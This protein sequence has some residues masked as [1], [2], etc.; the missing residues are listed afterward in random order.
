MKRESGG[1][2]EGKPGLVLPGCVRRAKGLDGGS[3]T[4]GHAV[5]TAALD[6]SVSLPGDGSLRQRSFWSGAAPA[7]PVGPWSTLGQNKCVLLARRGTGLLPSTPAS[8]L[9]GTF[10][11]RRSFLSGGIGL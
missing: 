7:R 1:W 10:S 11:E 6:G 5:G 4:M 3:A 8:I 2:A 9:P